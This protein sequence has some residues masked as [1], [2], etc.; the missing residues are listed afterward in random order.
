MSLLLS[1]GVDGQIVSKIAALSGQN[2]YACYQCGKC[3]ASCPFNFT[4][5]QVVRS[6]Q[7]GHV[8]RA[9]ATHT[10]WECAGC[11]TCVAACPKGVDPVRIM[12][13]LRTL[14]V[15]A[16]QAEAEADGAG[17]GNGAAPR[18]EALAPYYKAHKKPLRSYLF[19]NNHLLA[20][21]GSRFAPVSN[22]LQ[23]FPG[24]SLAAHFLFGIHRK[25]A[26]PGYVSAKNTFPAWFKRHTPAGD[27]HRGPVLLFHDTYMDYSVPDIGIAATELLEKAGF[28]VELTDTECCGRAMIS[29]TFMD[30]ATKQACVNIP[31]LY[32]RA[33]DGTF[34]VGCEPSC[35]LTLRD[36]YPN[37][38]DDPELNEQARV[39]A[40]QSLLI[41]EF[42]VMLSDQGELEL[43]F[44]GKH[45]D[46]RAVVFHGHCQQK[47]LADPAKSLELLRLAGYETEFVNAIC[48]GMAGT[49]GYEKEHYA[50]SKATFERD[51]GPA[52]KA[53]PDAQVVVMGISCRHQ[54]EGFTGR[55]PLH[56]A[57]ALR[58]AV[59]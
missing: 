29:K 53:R 43:S 23:G 8:E 41:D 44:N 26:L 30:R 18:Y 58:D 25:R 36:E 24:A 9:L 39:V 22:W 51:V 38:V 20:R 2:L 10:T 34:I 16:L 21:W 37:L 55:R 31:S 3:T 11:Q 17:A 49:F 13:A 45:A 56:L 32:E 54:I 48:C 40:Q 46:G 33:R 7:L 5:Q 59:V 50:V 6:V 19:A 14:D 27:G 47:A 1:L 4:P 15:S 35:L 12:R 57:Q 52:L 42:L 28:K